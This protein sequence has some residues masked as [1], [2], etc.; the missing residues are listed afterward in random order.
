MFEILVEIKNVMDNFLPFALG[1]V[2]FYSIMSGIG[3]MKPKKPK[4]K[5][6]MTKTHTDEKKTA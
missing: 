5:I 2:G 6:V 3:E 1:I 4:K